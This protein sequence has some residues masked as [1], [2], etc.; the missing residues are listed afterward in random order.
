VK[1]WKFKKCRNIIFYLNIATK[2]VAIL[3][4]SQYCDKNCRNIIFYLNIATKTVAIL[5]LSLYCDKNCRNIIF[6]SILRQKLSQ[7]D[8]DNDFV[9]RNEVRFFLFRRE[10]KKWKNTLPQTKKTI[11][12]VT[13]FK[14]FNK[15]EEFFIFPKVYFTLKK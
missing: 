12:H 10:L 3:F 15:E 14:K 1:K 7:N 2:T 8:C 6:I 13:Y 4:L 5:F 11:F 9:P